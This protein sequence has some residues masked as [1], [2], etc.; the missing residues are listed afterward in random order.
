MIQVCHPHDAPP[1]LSVS[2]SLHT[3]QSSFSLA[4][5]TASD[6]PGSSTGPKMTV[7]AAYHLHCLERSKEPNFAQC[8]SRRTDGVTIL[9]S[10]LGQP[11][12]F[13]SPTFQSSDHDPCP[14]SCFH[15]SSCLNCPYQ[16]PCPLSYWSR[17]FWEYVVD[18]I[19]QWVGSEKPSRPNH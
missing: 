8:R 14:R 1:L 18:S 2:N 19:L 10:R 3:L 15:S 16:R 9:G 6:S 5:P 4:A 17:G 13:A 11:T 7:E 12:F